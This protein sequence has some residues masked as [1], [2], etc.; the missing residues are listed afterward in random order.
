[1]KSSLILSVALTVGTLA[2]TPA[3]AF[4]GAASSLLGGGGGG[5]NVEQDVANFN[6]TMNNA[7]NLLNTSGQQLMQALASKEQQAVFEEKMK[8]LSGITDAKEKNAKMVEIQADV[9]ALIKQAE[10][11]KAVQEELKNADATKKQ[12]VMD[13]SFNYALGLLQTV[14]LIATGN[15]IVQGVMANPMMALKVVPIKDALP[16]IQPLASGIKESTGSL[17]NMMKAADIKPTLPTSAKGVE[18]KKV[19]SFKKA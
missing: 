6:T 14:E 19:T 1:M 5:G 10:T 15:N 17:I 11:N 16:L 8:A 13:A 3:H 9:S 4:L 12:F 18:P 7:V 2:A